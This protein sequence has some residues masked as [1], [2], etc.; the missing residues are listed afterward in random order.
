[1]AVAQILGYKGKILSAGRKV[2]GIASILAA[3]CGMNVKVGY[4]PIFNEAAEGTGS[5]KALKLAKTLDCQN[6]WRVE[7]LL[8]TFYICF[9]GEFF[10]I[11]DR[12]TSA[13]AE[14]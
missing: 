5:L 7:L 13:A 14:I 12:V 10:L 1:V 11:R 4:V 2:L 8:L 9:S 3:A 6:V